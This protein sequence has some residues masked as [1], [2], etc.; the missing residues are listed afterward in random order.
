MGTL[1]YSPSTSSVIPVIAA[2]QLRKNTL[3]VFTGPIGG[4]GLG[5]YGALRGGK[6]YSMF[7]PMPGKN[8]VLQYCTAEKP[9]PKSAA[10]SRNRVVQL[11]QGLVAPDPLERFDFE[12]V[13][14]PEEK[15]DKLIVLQG[16]IR[17]DG[18]VDELKLYQGV[19]RDMD[20]AALAAFGRW[21]FKPALRANQPVAVEILV[22]I[23]ARVPKS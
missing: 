12:R 4:G 14:V 9:V 16:V 23:P 15:A 13:P 21:R 8:W 20:Q 18:T 10:G 1:A 2:P 11:D 5:V 3:L 7:L 19:H 22:G 6:I 17:A